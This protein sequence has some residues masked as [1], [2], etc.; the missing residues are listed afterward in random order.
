MSNVFCCDSRVVYRERS[1]VKARVIYFYESL[2]SRC[3][4][5]ILSFVRS[6]PTKFFPLNDFE[7]SRFLSRFGEFDSPNRVIS[8][9]GESP[10]SESSVFFKRFPMFSFVFVFRLAWDRKL[11]KAYVSKRNKVF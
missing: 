3:P 7:L 8:F 6:Y 10:V 1:R 11:R 5:S 4:V 2:G 9:S